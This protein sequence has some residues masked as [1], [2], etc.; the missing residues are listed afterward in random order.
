MSEDDLIEENEPKAKVTPFFFVTATV[1]IS[2]FALV[3]VLILLVVT[4]K[5]FTLI[6]LDGLNR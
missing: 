5:F 1:I 3:C 4:Y 2:V 6:L